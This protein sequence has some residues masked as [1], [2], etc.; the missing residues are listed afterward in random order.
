MECI[1]LIE[2]TYNNNFQAMISVA[3][4]EMLYRR[5]CKSPVHWDEVGERCYLGPDIVRNTAEVVEKI[6]K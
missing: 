4:Y 2:F 6:R 3:P 1:S 5:K